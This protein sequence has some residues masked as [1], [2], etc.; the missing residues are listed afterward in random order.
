MAQYVAI[1]A[2]NRG[3]KLRVTNSAGNKVGL[4]TTTDVVI[5]LDLV[6]NRLALGHHQAVGQWIVSATN[7]TEGP[8]G[9]KVSLP[10]NS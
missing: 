2:L 9:S 6:S 8:A 4:S 3:S 7:V 10:S 1:R 5:D